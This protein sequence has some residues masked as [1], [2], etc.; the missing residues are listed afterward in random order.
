MVNLKRR[1][2]NF[3]TASRLLVVTAFLS[4]VAITG[5][6]SYLQLQTAPE[7]SP[8][9]AGVPNTS[10]TPLPTPVSFN[11]ASQPDATPAPAPKDESARLLV[12]AN[13]F[14]A[15]GEP[16]DAAAQYR[17]II[18]NYPQ[19]KEVVEASF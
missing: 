7:T 2:Q 8:I 5:L 4:V 10:P 1:W 13:R 14:L 12:L 6:V 3:S 19:S 15:D 17:L 16:I 11:Y 18:S 9:Q